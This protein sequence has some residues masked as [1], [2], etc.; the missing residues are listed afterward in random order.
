MIPRMWSRLAVGTVIKFH[1]AR[2][3]GCGYLLQ[4]AGYQSEFS[5]VISC[6]GPRRL[7]D[8]YNQ[9]KME[10]L[11]NRLAVAVGGIERR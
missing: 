9:C 4:I 5:A 1:S 6:R 8:G 11:A 7:V 10:Q 2:I 3:P